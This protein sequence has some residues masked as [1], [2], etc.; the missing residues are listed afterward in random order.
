MATPSS[1]YRSAGNV[2]SNRLVK[3]DAG[4]KHAHGAIRLASNRD[5]YGSDP[6]GKLYIYFCNM[7]GSQP[8]RTLVILT[9]KPPSEKG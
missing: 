6:W 5:V 9:Q 2:I 8:G 7:L 3:A 4:A 1:R